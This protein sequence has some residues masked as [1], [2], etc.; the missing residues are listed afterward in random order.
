VAI[1]PPPFTITAPS[2]TGT[3]PAS[4]TRSTFSLAWSTDGRGDRMLLRAVMRNA[5]G[6]AA[7]QTVTCLLTDDG[8]FTIPS[9]AWAMF[10]E[11]RV[12]EVW[13]T[14]M[15]E[16]GGTLEHSGAENRVVGAATHVGLVV[17]H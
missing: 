15:V 7:A 10:P 14:R 11:G 12:I 13:L 5:E 4:V 16:H 3:T 8:A 2:M 1:I 17:S 9:S 6:T